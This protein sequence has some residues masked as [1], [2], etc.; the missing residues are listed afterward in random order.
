MRMAEWTS[1]DITE[2]LR[3]LV[4]I[5]QTIDEQWIEW[6]CADM[7]EARNEIERLRQEKSELESRPQ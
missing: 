2:K 6:A 7:D 3:N 5:S 1:I 4:Y